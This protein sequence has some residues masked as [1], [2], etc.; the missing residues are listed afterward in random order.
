MD[1]VLLYSERIFALENAIKHFEHRYKI[2]TAI[3]L[4]EY[5]LE[6][7]WRMVAIDDAI[8]NL[9]KVYKRFL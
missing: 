3:P 7:Y 1:N 8:H 6:V 5:E 9:M 2:A 4:G